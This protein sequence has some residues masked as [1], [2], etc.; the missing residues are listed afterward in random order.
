VLLASPA[1]RYKLERM[2]REVGV[3]AQWAPVPTA[4]EIRQQDEAR[5]KAEVEGALAEAPEE[6]LAAARGLLEGRDPAAVALAL[7]RR[8]RASLPAAEELPETARAAREAPRGPRPA[9][10][11]PPSDAMWFRLT[12]GREKKADPKWILPLVCRRGGVTRDEIGKIVILATETRFQVA[13]HAAARF[14]DAARVPDPRAPGLRI[15]P[16]RPPTDLGPGGP[17]HRAGAP[18]HR[19]A[20]APAG[21]GGAVHGDG[22]AVR[23][24]G[25]P[26]RS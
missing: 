23:R 10:T 12:I 15:D 18:P 14:A 3:Q 24:A 21:R 16:A 7:L 25:K 19:A 8:H 26:R 22:H 2:L 20:H 17:P 11:G 4:E 1:E 5:L 13:S 9:R 6:E